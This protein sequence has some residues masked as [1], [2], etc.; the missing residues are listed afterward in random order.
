MPWDT[1]RYQSLGP[2]NKRLRFQHTWLMNLIC[3]RYSRRYTVVLQMIIIFYQNNKYIISSIWPTHVV[4][5]T[6]KEKCKKRTQHLNVMSS[7]SMRVA[8]SDE[9]AGLHITSSVARRHQ[10]P[11][12]LKKVDSLGSFWMWHILCISY[13]TMLTPPN[14][15]TN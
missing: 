6:R 2:Q 7:W 13:Q 15:N 5:I 14:C 12:N 9:W 4:N 10:W 1:S 3:R 11:K 8:E